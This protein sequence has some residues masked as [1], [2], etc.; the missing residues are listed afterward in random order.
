GTAGAA[1]DRRAGPGAPPA[2]A[3]TATTSTRPPNAKERRDRGRA[4]TV[5]PPPTTPATHAPAGHRHPDAPLSANV[6]L[7]ERYACGRFRTM[8]GDEQLVFLA[9]ALALCRFG[10]AL[11]GEPRRVTMR[12]LSATYNL[13]GN[14]ANSTARSVAPRGFQAESR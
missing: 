7:G 6:L 5:P 12:P 14:A 9:T 2:T 10:I 13:D 3:A 4:A 1:P 8:S 11:T